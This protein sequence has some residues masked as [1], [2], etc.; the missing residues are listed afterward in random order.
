DI[1]PL[2]DENRILVKEGLSRIKNTK[3]IGMKALIE[4][5]SL[6]PESINC[7][8]F[9]FVLGPCINAAGR[10]DTAQRAFSLFTERDSG[11]AE[12]IAAELAALNAER[13]GM[14]EQGVKLAK[15]MVDEGDYAGDRV[16]VLYIPE[17]HESIAGIIAGRVREA[18]YRP[19]FILTDAEEG[20]KGSGRSIEGYMMYDELC[21]CE[22][23]LLKFGGHPMAAGLTLP[24]E[25]I[26][27]FRKRLNEQC[28]LSEQ[29]LTEKVHIDVPMPVGYVTEALIGELSRLEPYGTGN[30]R[31]LFADRDLSVR[32][33]RVMGKNRNVLK[34]SLM[35]QQGNTV[36]GIYFGDIEKFL[37]YM[38]EKFGAD[39]LGRALEGMDNGIVISVAYVPAINEF[40]GERSIQFEIKYYR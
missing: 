38:E 28:S 21:K 31:P 2:A 15:L 9:G 18:Y 13:K 23:L 22:D 33:L 16:L 20:V 4:Q 11:K 7:Y 37:S 25:N 24:H 19:T 26:E 12:M 1:V 39:E 32:R 27:I 5:C 36:E 3:N 29:D 34:L 30:P 35:P 8:H 17:V 40:R 14:T 6:S 10:L